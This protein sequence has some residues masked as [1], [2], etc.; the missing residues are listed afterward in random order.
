MRMGVVRR[1]A[2]LLGVGVVLAGCSGASF[3]VGLPNWF[4]RSNSATTAQASASKSGMPA[5]NVSDDCPSAQIRTGAGTLAVAA[6]SA[7]PTA[8]DLRYQLTFIELA[9]QCFIDGPNVRMQVGVQGRAVVGPAGAPPQVQVPLRYAVVREGVAPKTIVTKFRRV[10][11][12]LSS[13][14]TIFTDIEE[15][16]TFPMP[17]VAE[18]EAY[19]VY[20]GFDEMGEQQRPQPKKKAPAQQ[21]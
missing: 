11:V 5:M 10:S 9:R 6:K 14:N 12:A 21:R 7:Q 1:A 16:L 13:T 4:T 20:V 2:A 19:V 8:S 17:P 15:D 3:N 18:L